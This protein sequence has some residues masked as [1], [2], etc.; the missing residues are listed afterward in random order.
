MRD[1]NAKDRLEQV[2]LS[3]LSRLMPAEIRGRCERLDQAS[4][5]V[6][7]VIVGGEGHSRVSA[8][9][10]DTDGRCVFFQAELAA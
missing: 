3:A 9:L 8:L 10:Y 6:D 2:A 4:L 5:Q 7:F 1:L